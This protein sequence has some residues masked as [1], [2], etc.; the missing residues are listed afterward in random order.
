MQ[1]FQN[2]K[3]WIIGASSGIGAAL[4]QALSKQGA[5][6]LLSARRES[7]LSTLSSQ[8]YRPATL[9]PLD[10]SDAEALKTVAQL[11]GPFDSVIFLAAIY[12]PGLLENMNLLGAHQMMNI[13]INSALNTIDAVYPQMRA[14][15]SGQIVLCGSV[16]AYCGLPNSQPYSMTKA[17]IMSLAQTLKVEAQ[18]FNIDVKLI[19]PGFVRTPLTAKNNFDMPMMIEAGEAAKAIADGLLKPGFEIHFPK[20]LTVAMKILSAL[21]YALYFKIADKILDKKINSR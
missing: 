15:R 1:D 3:I 4:A 11:H 10:V 8:L 6:I 12:T 21:P 20:K 18:R 13:N 9:A 19:S 5:N 2:K 14:R 16:A 7:E 17:A